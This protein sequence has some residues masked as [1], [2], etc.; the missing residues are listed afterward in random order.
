[1]QNG[2]VMDQG[3]KADVLSP[4]CHPYTELLLSSVPEMRVGW[5]S[6]GALALNPESLSATWHGKPVDLQRLEF[7]LLWQLAENPQRVFNRAALGQ[8]FA[9][10]H[11]KRIRLLAD[12]Q[13]RVEKT[14]GVGAGLIRCQALAPIARRAAVDASDEQAEHDPPQAEQQDHGRA[15]GRRQRKNAG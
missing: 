4:P 15:D 3:M 12:A 5:L 2:R 7:M 6:L 13:R 1:M 10:L 11:P 8:L 14:C 9:G